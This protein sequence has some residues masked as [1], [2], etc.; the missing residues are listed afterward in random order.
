MKETWDAF[1]RRMKKLNPQYNPMTGSGQ[2]RPET[3][4]W[5]RDNPAPERDDFV[6]VLL[7]VSGL[8][9][10]VAKGYGEQELFTGHD[11]AKRLYRM[12]YRKVA[13]PELSEC[14]QCK[15]PGVVTSQAICIDCLKKRGK[16]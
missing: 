11:S 2:P 12:G 16:Q 3:W 4:E 6:D 13:A 14:S 1:M 7:E 8:I 15:T 10:D 9:R 5:M